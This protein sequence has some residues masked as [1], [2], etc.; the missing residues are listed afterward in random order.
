M[1]RTLE[2]QR[3]SEIR[4]HESPVRSAPKENTPN[5]IYYDDELDKKVRQA[6]QKS[7]EAA[8]KSPS[9]YK[10]DVIDN[11]IQTYLKKYPLPNDKP[12]LYTL[13]PHLT[14]QPRFVPS[15]RVYSQ[16]NH[17]T[18]TPYYNNGVSQFSSAERPVQHA[19]YHHDH[20]DNYYA[21]NSAGKLVDITLIDFY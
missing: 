15:L 14:M 3:R 13:A 9:K 21:G 18:N 6:V 11:C 2:D 5:H 1:E 10:N 12:L 19:Q 17:E 8:N 4:A 20:N 16:D 7:E